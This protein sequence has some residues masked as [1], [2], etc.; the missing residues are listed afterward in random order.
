MEELGDRF[1]SKVNK[2]SHA[3]C[4]LW[5]AG[6]NKGYGTYWFEKEQQYAHIVSYKVHKGPVP[7][8]HDVHHTCTLRACI[9]PD[10]LELIKHSWHRL[11]HHRRSW[12]L[13]P[14]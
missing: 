1:W 13:P 11:A 9:N 6:G 8:G 12:N 5:T 10:H 3:P 14:R 2:I 7:P 4:W